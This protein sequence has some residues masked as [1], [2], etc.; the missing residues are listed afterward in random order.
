[1]NNIKKIGLS[2][3]A[4]SLASFSAHAVDVNFSGEVQVIYSDAEGNENGS[5]ASNGKGLSNDQDI[6]VT[7]SG[8]LD[9]GWTVSSSLSLNTGTAVTNS[10]SQ[11]SVGMGSLGT[12]MFANTLGTT[13][14]AIDDVLPK[15]YEEVWDGT[16]HTE[17]F[18]DFGA[19][20]QD[21]AMEY[22]TPAFEMMGMTISATAAYDSSA[23]QSAA[24][25]AGVAATSQSGTAYTVKLAHDSGFTLGGGFEDLSDSA[26]GVPGDQLSTIYALYANGPL[27]IGYQETYDNN[28][29]AADIESDGYGI[30][31]TSGD[32]SVSY[33]VVED[34]KKAISAVAAGAVTAEMSAIQAAY[35]MG[36][37][38]LAASLYETDNPEYVVGEY[39]ETELSVSFA[40]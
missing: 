7:A 18:S 29:A 37:M 22:R 20:T 5:A 10:S 23:G 31:Y 32:Y 34:S 35:T 21:G 4:G 11:I 1:M 12:V 24:A 9:N 3:L 16:T 33:A 25:S 14:N 2:A 40:F 19:A 30:A 6:L 17:N 15:A 38:T 36:A 27:S 39:E 26:A 28:G 13:S 8:E